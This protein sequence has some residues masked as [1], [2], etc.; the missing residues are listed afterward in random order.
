MLSLIIDLYQLDSLKLDVTAKLREIQNEKIKGNMEKY[1][2]LMKND[3]HA[4]VKLVKKAFLRIRKTRQE[5]SN[6]SAESRLALFAK[7]KGF[8]VLLSKSPDLFINKKRVEVKRPKV[9][10]LEARKQAQKA[11]MN[12]VLLLIEEDQCIVEDITSHIKRGFKQGADVVAI[13][14]NH[15]DKRPL[16]G[17]SSKW[18]GN[19]VEL[20]KAL[21]NAVNYNKKGIVL[22]FKCRRGRYQ[23]RVLRCKEIKTG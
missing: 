22:L 8:D 9:R 10:Y 1:Q 4:D 2:E 13:E 6:M 21:L 17:F 5:L 19:A 11:D 14:V 20:E 23:G 15:L 12:Y 16:S 18:L 7:Q 3:F